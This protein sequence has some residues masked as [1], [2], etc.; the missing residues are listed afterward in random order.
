MTDF[1]NKINEL[2]TQ[3]TLFLSNSLAPFLDMLLKFTKTRNKEDT[4]IGLQK[5]LKR[6]NYWYWRR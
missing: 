6:T 1:K 4:I 5:Q 3:I 2:G